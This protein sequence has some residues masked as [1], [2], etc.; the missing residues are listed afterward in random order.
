LRPKGACVKAL[1]VHSRNKWLLLKGRIIMKKTPLQKI[2]EK[3]GSKE[4][5]VE[6]LNAL[7][8]KGDLFIDRLNE[9]KGLAC[10]ANA[11]L[12]KLFDTAQA[13]K[14]K[15]STRDQLIED[16]LKKLNRS[17]DEGLKSK[18]ENWGLPRLW[19]YYK[20]IERKAAK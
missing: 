5:L 13:V 1:C 7:F 16:L 19:D 4:K 6:E 9:D 10:V 14:E 12:I 11:K 17:K 15:F 20:S 18:F 2:N 8:S 3:F